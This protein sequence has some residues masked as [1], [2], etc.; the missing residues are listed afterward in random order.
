MSHYFI[1]RPI[2]AGVLSLLM[3]IGGLIALRA[4]PV[5]EYPEVVPP[6]IVVRANYP[7]ANPAVIAKAENREEFK[8]AMAKI[9]LEV[10]R[11]ETVHS[12]EEARRVLADIGLPAVIR[13]SFT[14]GGSGS[15]IVFNRSEFEDMVR[16][17]LELSP[18]TEVL[19]EESIIGWKEYSPSG[20]PG[21]PVRRMPHVPGRRPV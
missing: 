11:G 6:Q 15:G 21:T 13:P 19:I 14:M 4:L 5:S 20:E 9:G 16:R 1:D 2:F 12:L 3:V 18:V 10:C 17:G 8:A 7:G